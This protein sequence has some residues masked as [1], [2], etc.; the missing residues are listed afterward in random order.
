MSWPVETW[1][2]ERALHRV[3]VRYAQLC[4]Q[5]DWAA[6]TEVFSDTAS[7]CYG[8]WPLPD[9]AAILRML[10]RHLGGCGP[11]QHLLG[12]LLV[13]HQADTLYSK[14]SV[15]AAHRGAGALA[16]QTYE[17]LGEYHDRWEHTAQGWRIAHRSM[18]IA[19]EFGSRAV[20]RPADSGLLEVHLGNG[21]QAVVDCN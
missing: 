2:T 20:L 19:L 18:V 17:C 3:L 13:D 14:V 10:Q 15:R 21:Q 16:E 7:A 8:G 5:R 9:R 12:N 1:L 11:T 6:I 4:D